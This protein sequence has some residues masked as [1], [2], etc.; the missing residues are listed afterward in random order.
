MHSTLADCAFILTFGAGLV[1]GHPR[2]RREAI[3]ADLSGMFDILKVYEG[4]YDMDL[5]GTT[6]RIVLLSTALQRRVLCVCKQVSAA[7]VRVIFCCAQAK[8]ASKWNKENRGVL[9]WT[10]IMRR[11][12]KPS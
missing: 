7:G 11:K 12:A 6:V 10:L 4:V 2:L 9:S 3:E 1:L 5:S 8:H